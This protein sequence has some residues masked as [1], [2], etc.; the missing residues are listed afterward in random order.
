M[1]PQFWGIS[2]STNTIFSIAFTSEL[3]LFAASDFKIRSGYIVCQNNRKIN[4]K[5][6]QNSTFLYYSLKNP[7]QD[8]KIVKN[9]GCREENAGFLRISR[10][11][12]SFSPP[13]SHIQADI[14]E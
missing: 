1:L 6:P 9:V 7:A 13:D 11:N 3:S 14:R 12:P 8:K 10:N 5:I 4:P 2:G